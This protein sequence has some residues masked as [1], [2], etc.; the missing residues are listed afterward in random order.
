[1]AGAEKTRKGWGEEGRLILPG[2]VGITRK[3]ADFRKHE[4][5]YFSVD[6]TIDLS[7]DENNDMGLIDSD[8]EHVIIVEAFKRNDKHYIKVMRLSDGQLLF[9]HEA[10][11]LAK[12]EKL[13]LLSLFVGISVLVLSGS[14]NHLLDNLKLM[15]VDFSSLIWNEEENRLHFL[16]YS[17]N[18]KRNGVINYKDMSGWSELKSDEEKVDFMSSVV[19]D[20]FKY[21]RLQAY[22]R[23]RPELIQKEG[24][25]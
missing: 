16:L 6:D 9:Y 22:L 17:R 19:V 1:M 7:I 20:E 11:P 4:A 12:Y 18:Y 25:K 24:E 23:K 14:L 8:D 10:C 5:T 15:R 13:K 2:R 21:D 3:I